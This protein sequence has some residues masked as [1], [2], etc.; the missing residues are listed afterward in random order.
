M[1]DWFRDQPKVPA[2]GMPKL[3]D[4]PNPRI[5][6][7]GMPRLPGTPDPQVP[8]GGMP[9]LPARPVNPP[10]PKGW[11]KA[12]TPAK[13]SLEHNKG[14]AGVVMQHFARNEVRTIASGA[15]KLHTDLIALLPTLPEFSKKKPK[16]LP[17]IIKRM[18]ARLQSADLTINFK[19]YEPWWFANK[20]TTKSYGQM[21]E[22][23]VREVKQADGSTKQQMQLKGNAQNPAQM[24]DKFDDK[25][26][27]GAN[28]AKD[29]P[30]VARVMQTGGLQKTSTDDADGKDIYEAV[31][32]SF[33]ARARQIFTA[34]NYGRR[35]HG[36]CI[37]YGL[38][39]FT[40]ADE[41]KIN[42]LYYPGDTFFLANAGRDTSVRAT[43][44]TL[45]SIILYANQ[46]PFTNLRSAI[47][48]SC[49]HNEHLKD[50]KEPH[51][52]LEAHIFDEILFARDI[53]E[54]RISLGEAK[55]GHREKGAPEV[56]TIKENAKEF[57][58]RNGIRLKFI[59]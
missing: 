48:K 50:T 35:K 38:S 29:L 57:C 22:R 25:M 26:T 55:Y 10:G 20:N 6:A 15:D 33:N 49:Y 41:K 3:P 23:A 46:P 27:F 24:R 44:G 58:E 47:I 12:A 53:R 8:S 43:Y 34:L 7:G 52:L 9:S 42:A 28:V 11:T 4:T 31:N 30:G 18:T 13:T 51:E 19:C 37:D 21:Y 17:E 39:Y 56:D 36:S 40:V 32:A 54:C 45:L 5:P 2:G 16:E 59:D 14:A 1:V